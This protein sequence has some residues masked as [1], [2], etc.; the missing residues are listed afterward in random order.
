MPIIPSPYAIYSFETSG[1]E[2]VKDAFGKLRAI[3]PEENLTSSDLSLGVRTLNRMIDSWNTE[4]LSIGALNRFST[5]L[6]AGTQD[7]TIGPGA[8]WD[9]VAPLRLNE[10]QVVLQLDGVDRELRPFNA[11]EFAQITL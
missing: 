2:I 9:T 5:S 10:H 4:G 3:D 1:A 11:Q 6:V 8:T 7:Y